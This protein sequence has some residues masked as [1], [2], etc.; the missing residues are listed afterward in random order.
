MFN[1]WAPDQVM[2]ITRTQELVQVQKALIT[3]VVGIPN[4]IMAVTMQGL[5]QVRATPVALTAVV[6]MICP[7]R[8]I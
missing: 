7:S 1:C 3:Q 5:A 4:L 2:A 8:H 6:L